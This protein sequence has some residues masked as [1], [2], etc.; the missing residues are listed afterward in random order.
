VPEIRAVGPLGTEV[1]PLSYLPVLTS[2]P[3]K[4]DDW[5]LAWLD[6]HAGAGDEASVVYINFGSITVVTLEQMDEFAWGLAVASCPFLWVVRP[7]MVRDS[8][9]WALPAG[10]KEAVVRRGM[11]VG[12]C[13]QEAVLEHHATG[14]FL[15]HCGWN[16]TI[17]SARA[18]I[19]MLCWP[20]FSEQVTN[21]R[22]ACD[23]WGVELEVLCRVIDD[24]NT[25]KSGL[26][27]NLLLSWRREVEAVVRELMGSEGRGA[28]ARRK[29]AQWKEK[30]I[31][32][33][34]QH[35]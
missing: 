8:G 24:Y 22:Y 31:S 12:W 1:S 4:P 28:E 26:L 6:G 11:M 16:S 10:F 19:R 13:D 20:F 2:S 9:G 21:C 29:A 33:F 7:D 25:P 27:R 3:W 15:N 23:E 14:G 34:L 5:C 30:G 17:E 32:V 18:G 35:I